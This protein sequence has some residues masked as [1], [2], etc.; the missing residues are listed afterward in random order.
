M[1]KYNDLRPTR[2]DDSLKRLM[3]RVDNPQT[4][5][6]GVKVAQP[7]ERVVFYDSSYV[8][9]TWDGDAIADFD[10]RIAEGKAAIEATRVSLDAAKADLEEAKSRI[11]ASTGDFSQYA[12]RITASEQ[13]LAEAQAA[14]QVLEQTLSSTQSDV[15]GLVSKADATAQD[16]QSVSDSLSNVSSVAQQAQDAAAQA[17]SSANQVSAQADN[18]SDTAQKALSEARAPVTVD[19]LVV[20][21]DLAARVVNAMDATV[22]RLVVTEDALLNN[23][24]FLGSMVADQLNV[25][26][27]LVARDAIVNG[28]LDVAQLN[29]TSAMSAEIVKAMSV[30]AKKLVV[31]DEAILNKATVVQSLVTPE[32]VAQKV[33][34]ALVTGSTIQT[35]ANANQGVKIDSTG[36]KAYDSA[37]NLAVNLDGKNNRVVGSFATSYDDSSGVKITQKSTAAAIDLYTPDWGGNSGYQYSHAGIWFEVPSNLSDRKLNVIATD[38]K[39]ATRDDPGVLLWPGSGVGFQGRFVADSPAWKMGRVTSASLAPGASADWDITFPTALTG[40]NPAIFPMVTNGAN[41]VV[42][43]VVTK[44]SN[45]GFHLRVKNTDT[46]A[47]GAVFVIWLAVGT[48]ILNG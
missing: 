15:Q 2:P 31:T 13:K 42:S 32:L 43:Y 17:Q 48:G 23:A 37:G 19:R 47:T 3:R 29:V 28:T 16:V 4:V 46:F 1:A 24:T 40:D 38:K 8:A 18:A 9:R 11:Q 30:E 10:S 14:Q 26:K 35:S 6:H 33:S 7:D 5:P 34:S 12:D 39:D 44:Q 36:Y 41:A 25:T 22:K 27:K 45:S 20:N 21:A